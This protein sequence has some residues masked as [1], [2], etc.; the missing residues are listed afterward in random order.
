PG[1]RG[2]AGIRYLREVAAM[3]SVAEL[4]L[5]EVVSDLGSAEGRFLLDP[6]R[7]EGTEKPEL[8]G[9]QRQEFFPRWSEPVSL[10]GL[11][12]A[13]VLAIHTGGKIKIDN[14]RLED[15]PAPARLGLQ[16]GLR[17]AG[18]C[19]RSIARDRWRRCEQGE[20]KGPGDAG[21]Q[22]GVAHRSSA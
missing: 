1:V 19:S 2:P 3:V 13:A 17:D 10:E 18:E 11:E 21:R 7:G 14:A 5:E 22:H 4:A 15:L 6:G 9:L 20:Q 16:V 12:I 8:P